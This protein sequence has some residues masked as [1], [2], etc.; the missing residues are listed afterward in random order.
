M[1]TR[2]IAV[3]TLLHSAKRLVRNNSNIGWQG[4]NH[5]TK[6]ERMLYRG[7]PVRETRN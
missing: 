3:K 1:S 2:T 4:A 5:D 6:A 7:Y